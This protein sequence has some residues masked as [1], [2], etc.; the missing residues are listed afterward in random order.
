MCPFLQKKGFNKNP[1]HRFATRKAKRPMISDKN[2]KRFYYLTILILPTIYYLY[3]NEIIHEINN[4]FLQIEMFFL[5]LFLIV[6]AILFYAVFIFLLYEFAKFI[7]EEIR[8]FSIRN[9]KKYLLMKSNGKKYFSKK[10]KKAKNY[11]SIK[12]TIKYFSIKNGKRR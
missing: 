2:S 1:Q 9:S 11:F 10:M 6:Q 4:L 7:I 12:N 3:W 8:Y 5:I